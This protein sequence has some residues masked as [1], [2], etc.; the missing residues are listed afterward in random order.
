MEP[1]N[2]TQQPTQQVSSNP[3]HKKVGPIIATLIIVLI[4]IIGAL[5]LFASKISQNT[6]P[7][8]ATMNTD[9]VVVP[10]ITNKA[11][12]LNSLQSDLDMSTTGVD[13]QK[14]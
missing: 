8:E 12:D 14:F 11:D 7:S 3:E 1:N 9:T 2:Q 10:T 6:L 13:D 4:L 5:Y